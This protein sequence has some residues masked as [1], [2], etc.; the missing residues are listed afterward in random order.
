MIKCKLSS[1]HII[2]CRKSGGRIGTRLEL[3]LVATGFPLATFIVLRL[4]TDVAPPHACVPEVIPSAHRAFFEL[5]MMMLSAHA[6]I[7]CKR[8]DSCA[9]PVDCET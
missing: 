2:S 5:G 1:K 8:V 9:Q 6:K 7:T 4:T 3:L